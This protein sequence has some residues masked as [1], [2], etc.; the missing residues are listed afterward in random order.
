MAALGDCA[1]LTTST[2]TW[3]NEVT[4]VASVYALQQFMKAGTVN[5]GTSSTNL[6]G[7]QNAFLT[8][9]NLVNLSTGTALAT[10]PAGNG[11]V[12]QNELN[13]LANIMAACV[14][15]TTGSA[16]CSS[17]FAAATPPNGT[18]PTDTLSA[19]L[20]I[21]LNPGH[22]VSTLYLLPPPAVAFPTTFTQPNDWTIG[23]KYSG[24]GLNR[25]NYLAV[26]ASGDVW[27]SN[28]G[29]NAISEFS[30][31][32]VSLQGTTGV[33]TST[34]HYGISIDTFGEI[35]VAGFPNANVTGIFPNGSLG[36]TFSWACDGFGLVSDAH[37]NTW[38]S[39]L[40]NYA[41]ENNFLGTQVTFPLYVEV[42][43]IAPTGHFWA[44]ATTQSGQA[45]AALFEGTTSGALVTGE[46]ALGW[47]DPAIYNGFQVAF[48]AL[49]DVWVPNGTGV[50]HF[51]TELSPSG[52]VLSGSG[53]PDCGPANTAVVDGN[54][55]M[56]TIDTDNGLCHIAH[57]GSLISPSSGY[58]VT[59]LATDS[60]SAID[61]AGN[62]WTTDSGNLLVQWVGVAGPVVTPLVQNLVGNSI[63]QRP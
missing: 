25:P 4:T 9:P 50:G 51:I 13:Y 61:S 16:Q 23:V 35:W 26:D 57:N 2:Y 20:D 60:F 41:C 54:N 49:G 7:L 48:D 38:G 21:A 14:N 59:G 56:W 12:P 24:G 6:T 27:I 15:S 53:F 31:A 11:T 43:N 34:T 5:V 17:L 32:G 42:I 19:M 39:A 29:S 33:V 8:V 58:K 40:E 47:S 37:G 46:P 44:P 18:A 28:Y 52:T 36:Q 22:N 10:T 62:L 63:G 55:T 1:N 30:P 3:V 45:D